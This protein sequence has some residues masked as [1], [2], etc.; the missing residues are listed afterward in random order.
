METGERAFGG[1]PGLNGG[2][3]QEE[4]TARLIEQRE[5]DK[6]IRLCGCLLT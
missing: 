6:K 5:R 1:C 4:K 2:R 3:N